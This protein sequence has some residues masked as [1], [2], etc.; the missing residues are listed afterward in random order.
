MGVASV[1]GGEGGGVVGSGGTTARTCL[2]A[3]IFGD[4]P[5]GDEDIR[6]VGPCGDEDIRLVGSGE[7]LLLWMRSILRGSSAHS[8]LCVNV[9]VT[10]PPGITLTCVYPS[11]SSSTSG[12]G[13]AG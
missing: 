11:S 2:V 13:G 10:P 9:E 8:E 5:C 7:R 3:A 4:V 12:G 6:L 1:S